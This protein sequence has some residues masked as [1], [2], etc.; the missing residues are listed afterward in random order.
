FVNNRSTNLIEV[1]EAR[2]I[3]SRTLPNQLDVA[4]S[5][6][7]LEYQFNKLDYRFN[8]RKG[9]DLN[10]QARLGLR[11]IKQNT[12]ITSIIDPN[13]ETFDFASLYDTLSIRNFQSKFDL[14]VAYY[15]P[16]TKRGTIKLKNHTGI[17]ITEQRA[18]ENEQYRIGGNRILRGFDDESIFADFFSVMTLEYRLLIAR[19]SFISVFSDYAYLENNVNEDAYSGTALSFGAGLT[20]DTSVGIFGITYAVGQTEEI[21]F[22]LRTAKIHLG[23]ISLF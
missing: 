19:N 17:L 18:F 3:S 10:V 21:P 15:F 5:N 7:G 1:D 20:F 2:I 23:Y 16:F 9:L 6:V 8:P 12:D 11:R 13:D 14:N 4:T 22:D